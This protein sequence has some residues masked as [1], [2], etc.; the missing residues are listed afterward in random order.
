MSAL[1]RLSGKLQ[2]SKFLRLLGRA[3]LRERRSSVLREVVGA[4]VRHGGADARAFLRRLVG[5]L[6][7]LDA[8][9]A[10]WAL[11]GFGPKAVVSILR[12]CGVIPKPRARAVVGVA[13][14]TRPES[15]DNALSFLVRILQA[16]RILVVVDRES[17]VDPPDYGCVLE[18][19]AAASAGKFAPKRFRQDLMKVRKGVEVCRI[20]YAHAGRVY[21]FNAR[22]AGDWLDLE[23]ALKSIH[24][25]LR[26]AGL[27]ERFFR[28]PIPGQLELFVF[29]APDAF[30][31]AARLLYLPNSPRVR[32]SRVSR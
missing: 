16:A 32:Q 24:A 14:M 11:Q 10:H 17:Q 12:E 19:F 28:M 31:R 25:A 9:T 18:R 30:R 15:V 4:L 23:A 6:H 2:A 22:R 7:P 27:S 21:Q 8:M 26:D 29:C 13:A 5:R 3:V 1:S 20:C